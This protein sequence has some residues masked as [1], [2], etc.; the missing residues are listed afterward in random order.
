[1]LVRQAK[2]AYQDFNCCYLTQLNVD[3]KLRHQK[4][5]CPTCNNCVLNDYKESHLNY[6]AAIDLG[7]NSFH[8]LIGKAMQGHFHP[9]EHYRAATRLKAGL[10]QTGALSRSAQ[11]RATQAILQFSA[12]LKRYPIEKIAVVGTAVFRQAVASTIF[13]QELEAILGAPIKILSGVEEA[14]LIYDAVQLKEGYWLEEAPC[15]VIDIGGGSCEFILGKGASIVARESL[16]LSV[17]EFQANA[18][19]AGVI[20]PETFERLVMLCHDQF[21][22]HQNAFSAWQGGILMATSGLAEAFLQVATGLQL[23]VTLNFESIEKIQACLYQA[24]WQKPFSRFGLSA[25]RAAIFPA[26]LAILKAFMLAFNATP[27]HPSCASLREGLAHQLAQSIYSFNQ[28]A[29]STAK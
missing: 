20:T 21:L 12:I 29:A 17:I 13:F 4:G 5:S 22:A 14:D 11:D 2:D 15:L 3:C 16:D 7:S 19:P 1:M 25:D 9:L 6:I 24:N 26:G 8:L 23:S 28:A 27:L 18:F 10:T